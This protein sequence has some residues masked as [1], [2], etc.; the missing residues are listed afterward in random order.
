MSNDVF[1]A[2]APAAR[3]RNVIEGEWHFKPGVGRVLHVHSRGARRFSPFC[4]FVTAYG[5]ND[6]IESHYQKGKIFEGG[7]RPRDWREAKSFGKRRPH[8]LG[9]RQTG[10]QIGPYVF[11]VTPNARGTSFTTDDAGVQG[12]IRMWHRYLTA[13]PELVEEAR[14]YDAFLDPFEGDFPFGQA[15]VFE[16]VARQGVAA[17]APLF[18]PLVARIEEIKARGK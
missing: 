15:K 12:Y 1:G 4:C 2:A 17:L 10:W 5:I 18:A 16:L 8:G 9:L 6:S 14:Q 3:F 11:D 13:R 7:R